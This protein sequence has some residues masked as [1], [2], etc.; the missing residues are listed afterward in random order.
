MTSK[1]LNLSDF[2]KNSLKEEIEKPLIDSPSQEEIKTEPENELIQKDKLEEYGKGLVL[3]IHFVDK[4]KFTV[5]IIKSFVEDLCTEIGMTTG[6]KAIVWGT[7]SN[8]DE[9]KDPKAQGL[10][11][12]QFLHSSSIV[13]HAIDSVNRVFINIFSCKEFDT[14][15]A[16]D[17]ALKAWGGKI[18]SE[19]NMI[20][21]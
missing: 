2:I 10:S 14:N 9:M 5:K 11:A 3:D 15:K 8:K 13:C 18:V 1:S 12:I 20:R 21:K 7:D 4:D 17:F 19:H 6:I 16:K